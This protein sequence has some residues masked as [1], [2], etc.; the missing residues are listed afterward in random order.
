MMLT[1]TTLVPYLCSWQGVVQCARQVSL[2]PPLIHALQRMSI[3]PC[4]ELQPGSP[5]IGNMVHP[6]L[7]LSSSRSVRDEDECSFCTKNNKSCGLVMQPW[8]CTSRRIIKVRQ[9]QPHYR[10]FSQGPGQ[11]CCQLAPPS[12]TANTLGSSIA[13]S[14]QQPKDRT[15]TNFSLTLSLQKRYHQNATHGT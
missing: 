6:T 3:H 8:N 4:N 10:I 11:H 7:P 9:T 14:D 2:S 5:N 13:F 12:Y 1:C 15:S